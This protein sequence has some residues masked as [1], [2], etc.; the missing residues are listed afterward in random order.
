MTH[1]L[2]TLL[3]EYLQ[4]SWPLLLSLVVHTSAVGA[5]LIFYAL[6]SQSPQAP[7]PHGNLGASSSL[8]FFEVVKAAPQPVTQD[9]GEVLVAQKTAEPP[10]QKKKPQPEPT[11]LTTEVSDNGSGEV[12]STRTIVLGSPQGAGHG[13][14]KYHDELFLLFES[15]KSYPQAARRLKQQGEVLVSLRVW[16]NGR[17][18]DH[19][20]IKASP[21]HR[22]NQAALGL[23][24]EVDKFKPLPPGTGPFAYFHLPIEYSIN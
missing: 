10:A 14:L 1:R 7:L 21:Y 24:Q 5:P 11:P 3:G 16:A 20:V 15:K 13:E 2:K 4:K 9:T 22:L 23:V 6:G 17:I 18:D 8:T 19:R 12:S